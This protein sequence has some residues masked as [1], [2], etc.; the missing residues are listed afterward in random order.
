MPKGQSMSRNHL[1][2]TL[3][4]AVGAPT[5]NTDAAFEALTWVK[6]EGLVTGPQFGYQ[7][8]T[9]EIPSLTDGRNTAVKGMGSGMDSVMTF[10]KVAADA[11][12]IALKGL[13]DGA[14]GVGS[15]K[16]VTGS[17][18]NNAPVAGDPVQYAQ[19]YFHSYTEN[20][21]TGDSYEG[22]SVSLRQNDPHVDAEEP[23]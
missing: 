7:H 4:V 11:G 5:A 6:V 16:V 22:F 21:A 18:A 9:I 2:K 1:G 8:A 20:Q 3:Y 17:G 12:Q 23:I 15:V 10:T 19:G 14:T 13:A